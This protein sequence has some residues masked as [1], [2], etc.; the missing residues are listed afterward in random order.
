MGEISRKN[1]DFKSADKFYKNA[2]RLFE[3]RSE[4]RGEALVKLS[5]AQLLYLTGKTKEAEEA[6]EAAM[7]HIRA[8]HLH[9]HLESFT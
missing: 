5:Q 9:T 8:H 7:E 2:A 4:P 1:G 3:G 6:H